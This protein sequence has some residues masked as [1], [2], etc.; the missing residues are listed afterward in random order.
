[1][2]KKWAGRFQND[3]PA[4]FIN[5]FYTKPVKRIIFIILFFPLLA[6]CKDKERVVD[7]KDGPAH[8][9]MTEKEYDFGRIKSYMNILTHDFFFVND[10]SEKL[11][12]TDIHNYCHCTHAEYPK[13]PIKPGH[14]GKIKVML[15]V[16]DLSQGFFSRTIK[17]TT[18]RNTE[19][20]FV[21]GT[22]ED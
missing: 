6:G 8:M 14:G 7:P 22:L 1:M 10:G 5:P 17:I 16:R 2:N 3:C 12:I 15:N 13:E 9:T 11:V 20:I 21:K 19:S 4:I 18:N